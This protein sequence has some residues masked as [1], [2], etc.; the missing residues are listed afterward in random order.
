MW[1]KKHRFG[2]NLFI[3]PN[4]FIEPFKSPPLKNLQS[5]SAKG[6]RKFLFK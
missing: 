6:V 4:P 2:Q 5:G 1:G 3:L